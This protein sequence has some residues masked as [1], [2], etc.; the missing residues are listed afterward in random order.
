[1]NGLMI[2]NEMGKDPKQTKAYIRHLIYDVQGSIKSGIEQPRYTTKVVTILHTKRFHN[3]IGLMARLSKCARILLDFIT[4]RMDEENLI[5]NN[6]TFKTE[7][8]RLLLQ[9]GNVAYSENMINRAFTELSK[10]HLIDKQKRRGLYKINP[11][12]FFNETLSE[13]NTK[14]IKYFEEP[15]NDK[16]NKSRNKNI[17]EQAKRK[18][19]K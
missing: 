12:F 19:Q 10:H 3:C 15:W 1:M 2:W 18:K 9:T 13:R 5:E 7:F 11:L 4:E 16:V 17:I 6:A 14:L 8:N